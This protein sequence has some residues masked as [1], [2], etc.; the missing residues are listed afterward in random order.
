[1]GKKVWIACV[2]AALGSIFAWQIAHAASLPTTPSLITTTDGQLRGKAEGDV[3]GFMG[4]PFAA[5][6][7]GVLRWHEPMPVRAWKGA[8][9][10][11]SFGAPC[12]QA[13]MGW[14]DNVAAKSQEDCLYLNVWAPA[15][16]SGPVPVLI[17]FPGGAYHG[18]SAEGLSEIEPSYDGGKLAARGIVVVTANYRLGMFGFLAH[19]QLSAESP[20]HVSGNYALMDNIAALNWVKANIA[21]FGGDPNQVTISGQSAGAF[22]VGFLMTSPLAKGLFNKVI[23]HSGTV[24]SRLIEPDLK[25]AE[26]SGA[27]FVQRF[28]VADITALR[29]MPA[30]Q[31][32]KTMMADTAFHTSEPRGP[33]VDG[34]V[35]PEQP[36]LVFQAGRE[37]K[38]PLIL[39]NTARDGDEDSM[40]VSGTP[41]ADKTLADK[42]RP[43]SATHKVTPLGADGMKQVQA[44]YARYGDLAG[45]GAQLYGDVHTTDAVDGDAIHAFAT[46]TDFRCGA[47]V[48]AQW[49][50]RV[51]PTWQFQF[52]HGY[53]P[54]GAVHLWDMFYLFGQ[55]K[56]PA[57]QPRD[58]TLV[59]QEQL[60]WAAFV[61]NGDPNAPGLPSWPKSSAGNAYLDF[62]SSGATA[63]TGLRQA[64]CALY[65]HKI[66]Q[67]L[68]KLAAVH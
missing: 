6:P 5:P 45:H 3:V 46:D 52:S 23:A 42:K 56:P 39:G 66:E 58:R 12:A 22:S 8:R 54:L 68:T 61:K 59:D 2:G 60:Y 47:D 20:H 64:A 44:Y 33:V 55:L 63:K 24:L 1:M 7:V 50:S 19:P 51:A 4:V 15:H 21:R 40:G 34:Y 53:E 27:Q 65:A 36:S 28:G 49:H 30:Q 17:F 14:N 43:I 26:A 32:I 62:T 13:A 11:I 16:H 48:I 35:F 29:R 37:D 18:G 67:D 31:L 25:Q 41:K 10:A 38:V 9:D 57:D